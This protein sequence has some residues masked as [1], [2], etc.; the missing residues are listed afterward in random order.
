MELEPSSVA[1]VEVD[2]SFDGNRN[3]MARTSVLHISNPREQ[4]NALIFLNRPLTARTL[5]FTELS[6][7][8][9]ASF[10]ISPL[11]RLTLSTTYY[12][13]GSYFFGASNNYSLSDDWQ[14][15]TVLQRFDGSS[16]SFFGKTPATL[17]YWQ[18]RWSF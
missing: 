13:D 15:L 6:W 14:M 17:L 18:L 10:D 2:Y 9:D 8:A 16:D 12:D 1:T 11:S 4:G 5:S 7:Y 3:W